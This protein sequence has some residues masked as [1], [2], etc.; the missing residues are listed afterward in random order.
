V[1]SFF[2]G[3]L[4]GIARGLLT[5]SHRKMKLLLFTLS[6]VCLSS[7]AL[8][9][10]CEVYG[11][12]DSPQKLTCKFPAEQIRLRC[13]N[14]QYYLNSVKVKAAYHYEVEEG[15]TPLVFDTE[16]MQLV[17]VMESKDNISAELE[18]KGQDLVIGTCR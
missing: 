3:Y 16:S 13:L 8:A 9:R 15:A 17:V 5:C 10:K 11:I 7:E 12:S 14:G 1:S 6:M 2:R 18:V 4:A